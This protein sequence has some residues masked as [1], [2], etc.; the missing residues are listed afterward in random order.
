MTPSSP[1]YGLLVIVGSTRHGRFGHNVGEWFAA[2]TAAHDDVDVTLFDLDAIDIPS[3]FGDPAGAAAMAPFV[4]AVATADAFVVVTPEYNHSYPAALK[5]AIDY[6]GAGFKGK[7]VAFASYGGM[8][9]GL[10]A[11][12]HL[13]QVF[14]ELH[15]VTTRDGVVFPNYWALFEDG[16]LIDE[17]AANAA[18]KLTIEQLGWWAR[19]LRAGRAAEP[20]IG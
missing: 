2:R 19:A 14:A 9:G 10:R 3:R 15:A 17:E 4:D 1:P 8:S 18:A 7:P 20:Y 5:Q 11:V 6:A 13:R 16:T 12:E